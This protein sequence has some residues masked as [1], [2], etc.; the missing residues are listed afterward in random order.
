MGHGRDAGS[1]EY[2]PREGYGSQPTHRDN[3]QSQRAGRAI[4]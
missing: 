2:R 4:A 1:Q 3:P